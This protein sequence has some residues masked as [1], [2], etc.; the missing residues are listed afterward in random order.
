MSECVCF[1]VCVCVRINNYYFNNIYF[2]SAPDRFHLRLLLLRCF[3]AL[4][5]CFYPFFFVFRELCFWFKKYLIFF[6]LRNQWG[7]SF[8]TQPPCRNLHM[9]I[10]IYRYISWY[11]NVGNTK[12][13]TFLLWL[14]LIDHV[15]HFQTFFLLF[16]VKFLDTNLAT[17]HWYLNT[18]ILVIPFCLSLFWLEKPFFLEKRKL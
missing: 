1:C 12:N 11:N 14:H 4:R 15:F 9:N 7:I 2:F 8:Q 18:I 5:S 13:L 3:V 17:A 6:C 10:C 16:F